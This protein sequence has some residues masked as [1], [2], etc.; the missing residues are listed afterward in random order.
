[1]TATIGEMTAALRANNIA[2]G[3]RAAEGG[4][5]DNTLGDYIALLVEE[6]GEATSAYRSWKLADATKP[7]CGFAANTGKAC[8]EHGPDKPQGVGSELA[9]ILIRLLDTG[10]VFGFTVFDYQDLQLGDVAELY[11]ER[12]D[13]E[14]PKLV[15]FADHMAWLARRVD[16]IWTDTSEAPLALRALVTIARKYGID[17]DFEYERKH[18]YNLTRPYRHGGRV[19]TETG[20]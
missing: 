14:L 8:A 12:S 16:K 13:P 5:G 15:S 2:H 3:F 20:A 7:V 6:I 4:P 18:A 11:P 9:D 17:L 19:L 10:D 1:M